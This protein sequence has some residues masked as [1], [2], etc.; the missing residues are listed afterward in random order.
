MRQRRIANVVLAALAAGMIAAPALAHPPAP[1]DERGHP[2]RGKLHSWMHQAKVPLVHGR[3][4]IK[5]GPCPM[6][7]D[8]VGCVFSARPRTIYLGW[9]ARDLRAVLYHE[10]GHVFDH[11]VLNSRERR[12]FKRII[13]VQGAGWSRG[14]LP[15][16]EWFADGYAECAVRPRVR[17]R[18]GRTAYGYA[19]T[20]RQHARVCRLIRRAAKPHGRRPQRPRNPPPVVEVAPP[21]PEQSQPSQPSEGT[22]T[23][24]D[25]LLTGCT[26][27]PATPVRWAI[28]PR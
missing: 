18:A 9:N 2:I 28:L 24:V 26:P 25:Q 27:P 13:G 22:C 11:L 5:R 15:A 17:R 23:L 7:P 1:V 21:P 12:Q 4:R 6:H 14:R 19:P 16:A 8:F 20:T 10:L 3:V